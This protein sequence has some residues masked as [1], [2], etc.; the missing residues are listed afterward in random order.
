MRE[1]GHISLTEFQLINAKGM[2]EI[3][4]IDIRIQ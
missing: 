1:K 2:R 3:L 4:K